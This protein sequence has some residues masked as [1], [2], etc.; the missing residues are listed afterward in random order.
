MTKRK[1]FVFCFTLLFSI[2]A[3]ASIN[4]CIASQWSQLVP[5]DLSIK[6]IEIIGTNAIPEF[7]SW[8]ILPLLIAATLVGVTIRNKIRKNMV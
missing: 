2:Y 7:P 8:T 1:T 4:V 3:L 6:T 5:E